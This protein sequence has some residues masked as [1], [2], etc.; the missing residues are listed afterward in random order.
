[1]S[2]AE[3]LIAKPPP[4]RLDESG[5][6]RV[7]RTRIPLDTVVHAYEDGATPGE[8]VA[9]FDTLKLAEVFAVL[10]YYLENRAEVAAYLERREQEAEDWRQVHEARCPPDGLR[11]RLLA[12][13]PPTE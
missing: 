4:L 11:E 9:R 2:I 12:R 7:G 13:R 6:L 3:T 1:M 10:S 5:T 8:I